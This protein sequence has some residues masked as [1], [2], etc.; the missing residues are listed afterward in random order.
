LNLWVW[1]VS[2]M[3]VKQWKIREICYRIQ[4]KCKFWICCISVCLLHT[5]IAHGISTEIWLQV[6]LFCHKSIF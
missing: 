4:R 2:S 5:D 6:L 3:N 1:L